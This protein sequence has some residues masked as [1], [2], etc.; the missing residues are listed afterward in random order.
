MEGYLLTRIYDALLRAFG[1]QHWWPGETPFEVMVGAVL[2]QNTNWQ[3]VERAIV[4]LKEAGLMEPRK[5]ARVPVERLARLIKPSGYFNVKALRLRAFLDW[6]VSRTGDGSARNLR[7]V[8]T[9]QLRAELLA[10]NGVGPET[11]DSILLYGLGRRVFVVDAYT[12]RFLARHALVEPGA[13]YEE[14]KS[15][16]ENRLPKSVKVYNEYHALIVKLGKDIC[17]PKPLCDECPLREPL[18]RPLAR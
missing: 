2:T 5:L 3:N 7:G 1:P 12:R 9:P 10:I 18:G 13:S 15:L 16:F 8:R 4:N 6:Y 14:I 11:A 17:R